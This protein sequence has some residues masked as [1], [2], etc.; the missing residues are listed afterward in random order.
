MPMLAGWAGPM[1]V[2]AAGIASHHSTIRTRDISWLSF[3]YSGTLII[4]SDDSLSL[5]I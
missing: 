2:F 3:T 1:E 5:D 4:Q